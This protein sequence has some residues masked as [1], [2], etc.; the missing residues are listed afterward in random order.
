[1]KNLREYYEQAKAS[2]ALEGIEPPE[3]TA[4]LRE[5]WLSGKVTAEQHLERLKEHYR[6]KGKSSSKP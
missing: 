2:A 1:M 3:E 4:E 5:E 6:S